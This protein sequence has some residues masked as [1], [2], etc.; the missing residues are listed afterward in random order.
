MYLPRGAWYDFWTNERVE[1]GREIEPAPSIS[2]RCRCTSAPARSSRWTRCAS[3]R[4]EPVNG[5]LTLTVYPGADGRFALY[6]DDGITFDYRKGEWMGI[7]M[8]WRDRD[9]RLALSLAP[10]SR[11]LP[12]AARPIEVRLAGSTQVRKVTFEGKPVNV[13]L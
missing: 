4:S 1:G 13:T 10:G 2:R 5:P 7:A 8:D 11:M 12:P 6:E 3:T 9:R